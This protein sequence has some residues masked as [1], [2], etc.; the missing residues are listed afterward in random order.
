MISRR[1]FDQAQSAAQAVLKSDPANDRAH[2]ILG[3]KFVLTHDGANAAREFQQA[4]DLAPHQVQHYAALAAVYLAA[5]QAAA[6]RSH[7]PESSR[8][9]PEIGRRARQFGAILLHAGQA[10]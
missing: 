3:E 5:G 1:Q 7:Q 10:G 2:A 8:G 9:Q 4:I 6:S